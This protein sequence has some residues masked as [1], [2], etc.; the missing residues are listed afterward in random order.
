MAGSGTG[1]V[2]SAPGGPVDC[3]VLVVDDHPLIREGIARAVDREA[4]MEVVGQAATAH[5]AV[6][7]TRDLQPA[8]IILDLALGEADGLEV[9]PRLKRAAEDTLILVLSMFDE[10]VY[11]ERCLRAGADGYVMK[12]EASSTLVDAIRRVCQG[13]TVVSE[14]VQRRLVERVRQSGPVGDPLE[15]LTDR[16]MQVFRM[17]GEGRSTREI[18]EGLHLSVKT[19]ETHRAKIMRKLDLENAHQLMHR[20]VS[21][22]QE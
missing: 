13:E 2:V 20:A 22:L 6:D 8:V 14:A 11:A 7:A 9:I 15:S 4:D 12:E 10:A 17:I 16:E 21:W 18:G 19:V 5:E 3:R 1:G